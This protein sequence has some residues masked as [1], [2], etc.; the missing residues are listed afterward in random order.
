MPFDGFKYF[1]NVIILMVICEVC[2]LDKEKWHF[3]RV[4][5][6]ETSNKGRFLNKQKLIKKRCEECGEIFEAYK[7]N[8]NKGPRFCSHKCADKWLIKYHKDHR[9]KNHHLYQRKKFVCKV[10]G[11]EFDDKPSKKRI[12]CSYQCSDKLRTHE[13]IL[14]RARKSRDTNLKNGNYKKHQER[15][16]NGGAITALKGNCKT[17]RPQKELYNIIHSKY[18]DAELEYN[19][20]DVAFADVG[21]PSLNLDIEY[22]GKHWHQDKE[23]D[24]RRDTKLLNCGWRTIRV[25]YDLLKMIK[26]DGLVLLGL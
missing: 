7:R 23:K 16:K 25:D 3:Q 15:M 24:K 8:F 17:S 1:G 12:T 18:I 2:G 11:K 6:K 14:K 13:D 5:Q 26:I 22:D 9:G 19:V 21:I 20:N 10:C 4:H